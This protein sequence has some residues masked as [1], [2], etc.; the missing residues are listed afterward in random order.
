[1][2]AIVQ[3]QAGNHNDTDTWTG[4]VVPT[5]AD[6]AE[7]RFNLN[8]I[9]DWEVLGLSITVN[10]IT[11]TLSDNK[12]LTIGNSDFVMSG[13]T[14]SPTAFPTFA[15]GPGSQVVHKPTSGQTSLFQ[16]TWKAKLNLVGTALNP[17]IWKT[18]LSLGGNKGYFDRA[19]D[20]RSLSGTLQHGQFIDMGNSTIYG[21]NLGLFGAVNCVVEDI[22]LTRSSMQCAS[23]TYPVAPSGG[24][25][26]AINRVACDTPTSVGGLFEAVNIATA[27]STLDRMVMYNAGR[28][29][30]AASVV[31]TRVLEY[32]STGI[33]TPFYGRANEYYAGIWDVVLDN[34]HLT[35]PAGDKVFMEM[36]RTVISTDRGDLYP[37]AGQTNTRLIVAPIR[38]GVDAGQSFAVIHLPTGASVNFTLENSVVPGLGESSIYNGESAEGSAA[39]KIA[40]VKNN[41]FWGSGYVLKDLAGTPVADAYP[42]AAFNYNLLDTNLSTGTALGVH[43]SVTSSSGTYNANGQTRNGINFVE[44]RYFATWAETQ[45][46]TETDANGIALLLADPSLLDDF[47]D[48]IFAGW[49]CA[50]AEANATGLA[51]VDMGVGYQAPSTGRTGMNHRLLRPY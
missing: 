34:P 45:N 40:S 43:T 51:G 49:K 7:C 6:T 41:I 30:L 22:T 8:I 37:V 15:M 4:G 20:S 27:N 10:S 24:S 33:T 21:L 25:I 12:I 23:A 31:A 1:M 9:D 38:T 44:K 2:T 5:S 28:L 16:C 35:L 3:A 46:G 39:N 50:D 13:T 26:F 48:Y 11:V 47:F 29:T 14:Y 19:S 18:D 17:W 42:A 32:K 36:P